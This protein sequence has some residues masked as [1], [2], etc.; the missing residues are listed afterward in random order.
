[1]SELFAYILKLFEKYRQF[2]RFAL[3]GL[4][5]TVMALMVYYGLIFFNV[6]Y[7]I[8]NI[9]AFIISSLNGYLWC[10]RWVFNSKQ[11]G[12][13]LAKFYSSYGVTFLLSV[14]IM[15]LVVE[16]SHGSKLIAPIVSLGATIPLNFMLNKY[17]TFK[18]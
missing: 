4:G 7:Q 1:M 10:C 3:V 11:D 6:N 5:N 8:A 2:I 9:S 13:S 14:G 15:F 18:K 17:W 12:V 16:I